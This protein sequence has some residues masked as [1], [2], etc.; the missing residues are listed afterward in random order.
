[1]Y[2]VN[3]V[4]II[5]SADS[6]FYCVMSSCGNEWVFFNAGQVLPCYVIE[7]SE[8]DKPQ[9]PQ[10]PPLHT[11]L[12][13][14][15]KSSGSSRDKKTALLARVSVYLSTAICFVRFLSKKYWPTDKAAYVHLLMH[16]TYTYTYILYI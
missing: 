13:E 15:S 7:V 12:E 11:L 6:K 10:P 2:I 1:M 14:D 3:N 8:C 4:I 5:I 16:C 9:K